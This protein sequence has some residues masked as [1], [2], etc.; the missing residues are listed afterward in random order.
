[1]RYFIGG[2][3]KEITAQGLLLLDEVAYLMQQVCGA[4][5]CAHRQGIIHRDSNPSKILVDRE[6]NAFVMDFGSARMASDPQ[7]GKRI[8]EAGAI[9][10]TPDYMSPEPAIGAEDIDHRADVYALD[11]M[12]FEMLTGQLPYSA[13]TVMGTL[14][15]HVQDPLPSAYTLNS[16][17][18]DEIDELIE[19]VLAKKPDE[20]FEAAATFNAALIDFIGHGTTN[21]PSQ[22]RQAAGTSIMRRIGVGDKDKNTVLPTGTSEQNRAVTV[23]YALASEYGLLVDDVAGSEASARALQALIQEYVTVVT[24]FEGVIFLQSETDIL[25]LWSAENAPEN[26]AEQALRCA[27]ALKKTLKKLGAAFLE[28]AGE[29]LPMSIGIHSGVV[30]LQP[31]GETGTFSTKSKGVIRLIHGHD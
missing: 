22:L 19:R 28:D 29:L 5:D 17:L 14:M 10:G 6:G 2:T 18:P 16:N 24:A 30:L 20:R 8:T 15:M 27:L 31:A 13:P 21:A 12:L 23:I 26:D 7:E 1:M 3:M 4:V 11:V 9:I 25:A